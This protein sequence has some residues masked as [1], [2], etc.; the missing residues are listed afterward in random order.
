MKALDFSINTLFWRDNALLCSALR[1][2]SVLVVAGAF[3]RAEPDLAEDALLMRALRDF[4]IP[5]IV[6]EDEV[7]FFGLLGEYTLSQ[8]DL[9]KYLYMYCEIIRDVGYISIYTWMDSFE[10]ESLTALGPRVEPN[11]P[12][13][14]G[15][16]FP[17]QNPPRKV[18]E[19]LEQ[20]VVKACDVLGNH[21]D[22]LFC[23]KVRSCIPVSM[24]FQTPN[25]R[26]RRMR[27]GY[28]SFPSVFRYFMAVEIPLL[29]RL[30]NSKNFFKSATAYSSWALPGRGK[31]NHGRYGCSD[32]TYISILQ[33]HMLGYM[34]TRK[35]SMVISPPND[36]LR[37]WYSIM[38]RTRIRHEAIWCGRN[39]SFPGKITR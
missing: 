5:K 28:L 17:G 11:P 36:S 39:E 16:L 14:P 9:R 7:V 23:L 15:D 18:D 34:G 3:K 30:C 2:K 33:L 21:P 25:P 22:D 32:S 6:R 29:R 19:E 20:F 38:Q 13:E 4:N 8:P 35:K 10:N 31:V 26:N 1:L 24:T 37:Y 12:R 27:P